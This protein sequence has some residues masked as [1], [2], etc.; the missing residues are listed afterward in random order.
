MKTTHR[1]LRS[2][3]MPPEEEMGPSASYLTRVRR[4]MPVIDGLPQV[5]RIAVHDYGAK[6]FNA[7]Y[8]QGVAISYLE[9]TLAFNFGPPIRR[10]R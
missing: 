1:Y 2:L 3:P 8:Q 9:E 5:M 4:E 10:I 7:V 6:A